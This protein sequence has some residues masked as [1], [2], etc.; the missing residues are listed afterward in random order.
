MRLKLYL[1][2]EA[3][4]IRHDKIGKRFKFLFGNKKI[5]ILKDIKDLPISQYEEE[6]GRLKGFNITILNKRTK[7]TKNVTFLTFEE[8][9]SN[10]KVIFIRFSNK[11]ADIQPKQLGIKMIDSSES[12]N[13]KPKD[14]NIPSISTYSEYLN[15]IKSAILSHDE[16]ENIKNYMNFMISYVENGCRGNLPKDI[17]IKDIQINQIG[18]NFGEILGPIALFNVKGLFNIKF[19]KRR[20]HILMPTASN[21][22]LIDYSI[23]KNDVIYNFSAKYKKGAATSLTSI[24]NIIKDNINEFLEFLEEVIVIDIIE[25]NTAI[26]A[27]IILCEKWKLISNE[28]V[29]AWNRKDYNN[30]V[31]D[32]MKKKK[33]PKAKNPEAVKNKPW[34][35]LSIMANMVADYMN[36][37]LDFKSVILKS[38]NLSSV[39]QINMNIGSDGKPSFKI[40]DNSLKE[41]KVSVDSSKAYFTTTK[42]KQKLSFKI[43]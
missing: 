24:Y 8:E 38:L 3:R 12:M 6:V 39:T 13:L 20:D 37:N 36:K 32:E 28:Q 11:I 9:E 33:K 17:E 43:V 4:G 42:P 1:L 14:F 30:P 16:D 2:N 22:K 27:P 7:S 18:K 31:W 34:W 21:E 40:A 25:T 26:K 41:V 10:K 29:K 23:K 5:H 35:I 15:I 19:N